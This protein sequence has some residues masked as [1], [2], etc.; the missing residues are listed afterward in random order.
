MHM[1][2]PDA[3]GGMNA[4]AYGNMPPDA[5]AVWDRCIWR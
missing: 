3:M 1:M 4:D 5:M 2:P